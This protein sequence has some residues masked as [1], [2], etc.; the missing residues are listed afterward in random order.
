M[1]PIDVMWVEK[2]EGNYYF[3]FGGCHRYLFGETV[4]KCRFEA[5]KRLKL[6]FV[7]CKIIKVE[8]STIRTYLGASSPF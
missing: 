2:E 8:P 4:M 5:A 7:R 3:S 6:S 1:T